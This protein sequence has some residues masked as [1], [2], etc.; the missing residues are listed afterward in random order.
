ME[1]HINNS[2]VIVGKTKRVYKTF[3]IPISESGVDW[4]QALDES[5][6]VGT[7]VRVSI[8]NFNLIR[9]GYAEVYGKYGQGWGNQN[10]FGGFM[11]SLSE[12]YIV[13]SLNSQDATWI[14]FSVQSAGVIEEGTLILTLS[15]MQD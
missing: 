6:P 9:L 7:E 15:Y 8:P 1:I 4:K 13:G 12:E 11:S 5:I 2:R 10:V 14:A 3:E